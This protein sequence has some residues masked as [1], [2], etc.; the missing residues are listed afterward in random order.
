MNI[1]SQIYVQILCVLITII[2]TAI[3]SF[4]ILKSIGFFM[5]IR[6]NE[7]LEVEGLDMSEHGEKGYHSN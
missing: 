2:W 7:D 5:S 4:L 6:V 1:V 3:G